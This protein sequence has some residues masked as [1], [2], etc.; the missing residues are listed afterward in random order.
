MGTPEKRA[1]YDLKNIHT[2]NIVP[3][4]F[5][6]SQFPA[7]DFNQFYPP[8]FG[9]SAVPRRGYSQQHPQRPNPFSAYNAFN[10][11]PPTPTHATSYPFTG[12][13]PRT[14]ARDVPPPD[15]KEHVIEVITSP[16]SFYSF[17]SF[18]ASFRD[19]FDLFLIHSA[20]LARQDSPKPISSTG[21]L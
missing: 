21:S 1:A 16:Y 3:N 5:R 2:P 20:Q 6:N 8:G 11:P 9:P 15:K 4:P 17:S 10:Q 13:H 19:Y 12:D 14:H 18:S 7:P